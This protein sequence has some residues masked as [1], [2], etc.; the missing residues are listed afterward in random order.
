MPL[1]GEDMLEE[2]PRSKRRSDRLKK[3]FSTGSLSDATENAKRPPEPAPASTDLCKEDDDSGQQPPVKRRRKQRKSEVSSKHT[4]ILQEKTKK[5]K[6]KAATAS[7]QEPESNAIESGNVPPPLLHNNQ[8]NVLLEEPL[9]PFTNDDDDDDDDAL[10]RYDFAPDEEFE[11]GDLI[12]AKLGRDPHWPAVALKLV[13]R[14]KRLHKVRVRFIEYDENDKFKHKPLSLKYCSTRMLPI[15]KDYDAH[16]N[17]EMSDEVSKRFKKAIEK[18]ERFLFSCSQPNV[19]AVD[20]FDAAE[21]S[22]VTTEGGGGNEGGE[23]SLDTDASHPSLKMNGD[24]DSQGDEGIKSEF[25]TEE[26]DEDR[27]ERIEVNDDENPLIE[28]RPTFSEE[29][30]RRITERQKQEQELVDLIKNS[31]NVKAHLRNVLLKKTK[32]KYQSRFH[33]PG[34]TRAE[35]R[36]LKTLG[37]G[38]IESE[39][40][41]A[42]LTK[43]LQKHL[44]TLEGRPKRDDDIYYLTD[45]WFPEAT[46]FGIHLQRN[47]S[48]EEA[49]RI[50]SR[51]VDYTSEEM[52]VFTD[53]MIANTT[54]EDRAEQ[55]AR[56]KRILANNGL[57]VLLYSLMQCS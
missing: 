57:D 14:R 5:G 35:N 25:D 47:V 23:E 56:T 41:V 8:P 32:S 1:S 21:E 4:G 53:D 13:K 48:L 44:C 18:V 40:H 31:E 38:P 15:S 27:I 19:K 17:I 51:G 2:M 20:Y 22:A 54:D 43:F 26:E 45:V 29:T 36:A 50:F 55:R 34:K 42:E 28:K 9:T 11:E 10:P 24:A 30:Y 52:A 12:W 33:K 16:K 3:A 7:K 39:K 6:Q 46:I 37:F 49:D